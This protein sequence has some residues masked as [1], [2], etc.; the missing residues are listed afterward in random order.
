MRARESAESG[1]GNQLRPARRPRPANGG[2]PI[3]GAAGPATTVADR[4][5]YIADIALQLEAMSAEIGCRTLA[6]LLELAH[7]EAIQ[8]RQI[9]RRLSSR[10]V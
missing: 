2:K 4:L 1:N 7:Q 8:Q 5:D 6:A 9:A 10:R 3:S